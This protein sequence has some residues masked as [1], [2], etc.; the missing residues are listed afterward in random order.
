MV[1]K[2]LYETHKNI[3][4]KSYNYI[5]YNSYQ[6]SIH[7]YIH[8][9]MNEI[10]V[11][12]YNKKRKQKHTEQNRMTYPKKKRSSIIPSIVVVSLTVVV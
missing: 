2:V 4:L 7:S 1:L 5:Q 3:R 12:F 8:P 10:L 11:E 6:N 9:S